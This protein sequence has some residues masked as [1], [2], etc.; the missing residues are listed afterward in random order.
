[1]PGVGLALRCPLK[2]GKRVTRSLETES[3]NE[4]FHTVYPRLRVVD[5]AVFPCNSL[6]TALTDSAAQKQMG[7]YAMSTFFTCV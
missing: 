1:M 3:T 7:Y 6:F 4:C 2:P 5:S